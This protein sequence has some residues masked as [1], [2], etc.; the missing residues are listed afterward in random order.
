MCGY[1]ET[2]IL[3]TRVC[4]NETRWTK[5]CVKLAHDIYASACAP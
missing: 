2:N 4:V 5:R 1:D 3:R